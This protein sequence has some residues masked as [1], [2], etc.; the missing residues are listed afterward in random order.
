LEAILKL[1]AL[2]EAKKNK[3]RKEAHKLSTSVNKWQCIEKI[4]RDGAQIDRNTIIFIKLQHL[5]PRLDLPVLTDCKH[6]LRLPFTIH[7]E[8]GAR[9][10]FNLN[11]NS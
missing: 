9:K 8:T 3:I 4:L 2:T 7:Q 1:T 10:L 6:L 5:H 11:R